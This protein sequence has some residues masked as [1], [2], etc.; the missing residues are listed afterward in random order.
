MKHRFVM[1]I[2]LL[3]SN[4]A[5][6]HHITCMTGLCCCHGKVVFSYLPVIRG[7]LAHVAWVT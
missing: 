4:F 1:E 5:I 7:A 3:I 2:K 6:L